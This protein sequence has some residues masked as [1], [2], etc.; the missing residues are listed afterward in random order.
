MAAVKLDAA[1]ESSLASVHASD[2]EEDRSDTLLLH[3]FPG[4][5]EN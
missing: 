3:V 1:A 4:L 5:V 2:W